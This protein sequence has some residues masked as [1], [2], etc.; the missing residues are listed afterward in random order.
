MPKCLLF[1]HGITISPNGGTRPCCAFA[2]DN[3]PHIRYNEDWQTRHNEWYE[4]SLNEWLP[5]CR[6]CHDQE[7]SGQHSMRTRYNKEFEYA[8]G[9]KLWDLKINNTCNLA[10][11][12]CHA[13][14]SSIWEQIIKNNSDS[15]DEYYGGP[16]KRKWWRD[17]VDFLNEMIDSR[18]IKFTGGEPFLIPQVKQIVEGL[19]DMDVA[20]GM[21]LQITTN[22]TVDIST[23]YKLF[24]QFESV[25]LIASIDAVGP[26][27]EY[28]RVGASWDRVSSNVES[29]QKNKPKNCYLQIQCLPMALNEGYTH[30]V[31]Q[32]ARDTGAD[33]EL[34]TPLYDP[35]FLR[36]EALTNPELKLKMIEQ[37]EI[38]D[39]IHG[40]NWR[41][42][43]D[44]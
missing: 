18:L 40:T 34:V 21:I 5:N 23:W 43:I 13:T 15:F 16:P 42:F 39:R 6:Q 29:I 7:R 1:K 33:Y 8:E 36:P 14:S 27:Y 11:R 10:C 3:V 2:M 37:L 24:E 25:E 38:Q 4:Q 31:E 44:E 26:R 19:I 20:S 32:W 35:E 22:G 28:I 9:I 41:D 17:S 12:M 30:L